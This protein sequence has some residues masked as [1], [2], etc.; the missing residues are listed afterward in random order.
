MERVNDEPREAETPVFRPGG[1]SYLRLPSAD[2]KRTAEFLG[3]VFG[4]DVD[5]GRD[6]PSFED[7][8]GHVIGH[9]DGRMTVA[10]RAG[11]RPY[12]YVES[13]E[14]TLESVTANGGEVVTE[15]YPEGDLSVAVFREPGGSVLGLWQRA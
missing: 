3:A 2:P 9:I 12:V 15:P 4:W 11:A 14:G 10:G 5:A 6:D 7:G 1:I 8:T 13:V